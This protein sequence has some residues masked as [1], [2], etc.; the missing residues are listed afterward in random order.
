MIR[1]ENDFSIRFLNEKNRFWDR[2]VSIDS[3]EIMNYVSRT[4]NYLEL[5]NLLYKII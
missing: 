5:Q 3:G 4:P 1:T 2:V